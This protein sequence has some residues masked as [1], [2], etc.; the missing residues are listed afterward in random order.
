MND[1]SAISRDLYIVIG[2]LEKIEQSIDSAESSRAKMRDEVREITTRTERLEDEVKSIAPFL[3]KAK[4]WE[5]RGIGAAFVLTSLGAVFGSMLV[6]FK[7]KLI[8]VIGWS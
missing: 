2:K 7:E 5:Q 3:E 1:F 4:K 6:G 8:A